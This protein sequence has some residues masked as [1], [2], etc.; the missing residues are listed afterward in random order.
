MAAINA[1][2]HELIKALKNIEIEIEKQKE[3]RKLEYQ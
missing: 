2:Y 3:K 1:K